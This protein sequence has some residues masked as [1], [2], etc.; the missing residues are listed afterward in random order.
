M[1]VPSAAFELLSAKSRWKELSVTVTP[2]ST[3]ILPSISIP[4]KAITLPAP[5][6]ISILLKNPSIEKKYVLETFKGKSY[7]QK[8]L[9]KLEIEFLRT[10][11]NFI[12]INLKSKKKLIE[13][14]LSK[15]KILTRKGPGV[16]GFESYLR[17]TLGP[18]REMEKVVKILRKHI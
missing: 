12:H 7:F 14:K 9:K 1:S 2:E 18:K 13:K 8:E 10:Y 6:V 11:A 3:N 17:I 5:E 16:S 4:L 15:N